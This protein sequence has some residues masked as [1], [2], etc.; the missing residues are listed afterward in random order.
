MSPGAE[1]WIITL[2][3]SCSAPWMEEMK[4]QEKAWQA[5]L[6]SNFS[7]SVQTQNLAARYPSSRG[8]PPRL[9]VS[10][11]TLPVCS[12]TT[13]L[14]QTH[15]IYFN[16]LQLIISKCSFKSLLAWQ[17]YKQQGMCTK[18]KKIILVTPITFPKGR[19]C[20]GSVDENQDE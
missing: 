18:K 3:S 10:L 16:E 8:K 1:N 13:E 11:Q 6:F 20:S 14:C 2:T 5:C 4:L 7:L 15:S 12:V 17:P 9:L 19:A